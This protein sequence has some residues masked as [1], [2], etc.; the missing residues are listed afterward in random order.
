MLKDARNQI[1][2]SQAFTLRT[3][4]KGMRQGCH[5]STVRQCSSEERHTSQTCSGICPGK[6][7]DNII[8]RSKGELTVLLTFYLYNIDINV[9]PVL[10]DLP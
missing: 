7:E 10:R 9:S 5:D 6:Q 4:E 1:R 3:T 2:E 8:F